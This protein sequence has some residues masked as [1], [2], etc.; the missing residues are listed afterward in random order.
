MKAL[1]ITLI[2]LLVIIL[3]VIG[4]V[5]KT[6]WNAG[7]F[8]NIEPHSS[9][10]CRVVTGVMS[11]ED[12]TIHP[13][14]GLAFISSDDRRALNTGSAKQGAIY[15]Y[16][17]EAENPVLINLTSDYKEEFHPHGIGLYMAEDSTV[18]LFVVNHI[19]DGH[20]IEIFD[21]TGDRLVHRESIKGPLM[22]S[23]N[24]VIPVGKRSFYVTNDHGQ[25]AGFKRTLEEYLQ[26]PWA[27]VL[28]Y[29]GDRFQKAAGDLVYANGINISRDNK[30]VYVA[31]TI[32]GGIF[33]YDRDIES[34]ALNLTEFIDAGTGVD[35]IE[36]DEEGNLWLGAHPKLLTFVKH[37][38]D[39]TVKSPS[40]V[41]KITW[42]K[43]KSY[44][45]K[46]VYLSD[47]TPMSSSSV[48]AVYKDILLI[49]SVFEDR[50]LLCRGVD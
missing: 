27:Y 37:A 30:T 38:K 34:G 26:L 20:Y 45:L 13:Q 3:V 43:D 49:G 50:F 11:S 32:S 28:Y 21:Y 41:L 10:D 7:Q 47:G 36:I 46:E 22:T 31:A 5:V 17:L 1:K 29:N 19:K 6:F 35:N 12:I 18:S 23:P 15:G 44:S 2:I 42:G 24:D 4:F 8:K 33:V 14:T 48:A 25:V 39:P 9:G 16:D 40:Q